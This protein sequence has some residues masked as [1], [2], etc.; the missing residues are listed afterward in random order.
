ML[1]HQLLVIF[2]RLEQV[3][4]LEV[5]LGGQQECF[6]E[7]LALGEQFLELVEVLDALLHQVAVVQ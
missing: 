5:V 6:G 3:V 7:E 2:E 1:L 4:L